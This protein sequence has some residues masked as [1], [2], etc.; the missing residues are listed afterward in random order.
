MVYPVELINI[1]ENDSKLEK[2]FE[3]LTPGRQRGYNLYFTAAKQ[4]ATRITR[5]Q[6]C[7]SKI[8]AGKGKDDCTCGLSKRM[9]RCDGSHK[10]LER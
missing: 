2:A 9:P 5:I 7:K 10:I 4:S 3:T 1:F 8:M 6:A